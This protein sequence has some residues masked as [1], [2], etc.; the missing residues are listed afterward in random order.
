MK[1][2]HCKGTPI[3]LCAFH[4]TESARSKPA[5][6]WLRACLVGWLAGAWFED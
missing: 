6:T 2:E 1:A 3:I 4:A 5:S